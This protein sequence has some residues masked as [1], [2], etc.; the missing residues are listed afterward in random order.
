MWVIFYVGPDG[1]TQYKRLNTNTQ[2]QDRSHNMNANVTIVFVM[3]CLVLLNKTNKNCADMLTI[4]KKKIFISVKFKLHVH[5]VWFTYQFSQPCYSVYTNKDKHTPTHL[6]CRT[7]FVRFSS[8]KIL[9]YDQG[10]T[11]KMLDSPPDLQMYHCKETH[12]PPPACCSSLWV[13]P[14]VVLFLQRTL[15]GRRLWGW[16]KLNCTRRQVKNFN[17]WN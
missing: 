6:T 7:M 11:Y 4:E 5:V 15:S 8:H 13:S 12:L 1:S 9:I 2:Q 17:G 3:T 14:N 16:A 10:H